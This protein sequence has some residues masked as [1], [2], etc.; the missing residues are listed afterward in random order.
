[1]SRALRAAADLDRPRELQLR[2]RIGRADLAPLRGG[3]LH[4]RPGSVRGVPPAAGVK[5]PFLDLRPAHG[6]VRTEL[7]DAMQRVVASSQYVLGSEVEAFET[8]FA[9]FCGARRC[10]GVGNGTEAIEL[11]LRALG[12]GA[13]DEVVTVSHTA[14]PTAAAV[15]AT[16]A[17]PVF[18]EV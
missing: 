8:E 17:T 13:G 16:G 12:V 18:V 1:V 9:A 7:A 15:T 14:F 11:V 4:P 6:E 5:V 10:V 2:R 3:R